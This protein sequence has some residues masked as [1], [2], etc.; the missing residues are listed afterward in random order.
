MHGQCTKTFLRKLSTL[1]ILVSLV[2]QEKKKVDRQ[3]KF[4]STN[5][6]SATQ[7][8]L[9]VWASGPKRPYIAR[10]PQAAHRTPVVGS[11]ELKTHVMIEVNHF[12]LTQASQLCTGT[13][14]WGCVWVCV[15]RGDLNFSGVI[16]L[17]CKQKF[18][19]IMCD[20]LWV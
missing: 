6:T 8:F 19:L 14:V 5:H 1:V 16:E 2:V 18:S 20:Y 11:S 3:S 12:L 17:A 13:T 9:D 7:H 15:E 10:G 4:S